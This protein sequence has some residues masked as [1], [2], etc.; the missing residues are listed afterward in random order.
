MKSLASLTSLFL[1]IYL[2]LLICDPAAEAKQSSE[3]HQYLLSGRVAE[4]K[5]INVVE[6]EVQA[7]QNDPFMRMVAGEV[8]SSLGY[9]GLGADQ[10][11]AADKMKPD[12]VLNEFKKIFENNAFVP[13]LMFLYLQDKYPKDPAVLLYA[14]RRNLFAPVF[15]RK[16]QEKAVATARKELEMAIALPQPWPGTFAQLATMEF[17]E[18]KL[19]L[20][21]KYADSELALH[22][23]ES[24]AEKIKIMALDRVGRQNPGFRNEQLIEMLEKTLRNRSDDGELNLMLG[25]AYIAADNPR[26][27]LMPALTGLLQARDGNTLNDGRAQVYELMKKI[28]ETDFLQALNQVCL[29]YADPASGINGRGFKPALL[30]I[31]VGELFSTCNKHE[32]ACVQFKEAQ[33]MSRRVA[34]AA[35]FHLGKEQAHLHRYQEAME[36]LDLACRLNTNTDN[37][38]KYEATAQRVREVYA[39]SDRNLALKLK[40]SISNR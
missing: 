29:R 5:H 23:G 19:D 28:D 26:K 6:A 34:A 21:I 25:R 24:L 13:A 1:I 18:G 40:A 39:N 37:T 8:L 35:S 16:E 12:F 11:S 36:S 4:K 15:D 7:N 3:L 30:R 14:A 27:A 10:Y 38:I 32:E 20:A 17:N 22:P 2:Y 33:Y 31:R 9:Y